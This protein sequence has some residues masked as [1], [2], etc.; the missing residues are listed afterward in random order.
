MLMSNNL[1]PFPTELAAPINPEANGG[2]KAGVESHRNLFCAHYDDCLDEAVKRG[3]NSFTCVRC[4]LFAQEGEYEGG[5]ESYA[6]QRR[7][8]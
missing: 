7:G 5:I 1:K 6:T 8:A 4:P 2:R 3:W